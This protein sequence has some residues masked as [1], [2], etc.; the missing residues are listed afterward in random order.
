MRILL[1]SNRSAGHFNPLVPFARACVRAGHQVLVSAP[2]PCREHVDRAGLTLAPHG[3]AR[4]EAIAAIGARARAVDRDE[5]NRIM[6]VDMFAGEHARAALP[7]MLATARS[8]KP[9]VILRET[10]E[11]AS[12][13]VAEELGIPTWHVAIFFAAGGQRDWGDLDG[14]LRRLGARHAGFV[15]PYLTVAPRS[16]EAAPAPPGTLRFRVPA[17]LPER[18][19][20]GTPLVY[21]TF[22]SI[23]PGAGFFPDLFRR[24]LDAL[25]GLDARVL[26]TIGNDADPAELGP[27]PAN[28][29]VERWV[30]QETLHPDAVICHGGSG[31]TLGALRLGV[32]LV[33]VPMFGDQI[34]NA[35]R[36]DEIGAGIALDTSLDG[37]REA[38]E[39]LLGQPRHRRVAE[40]IA[41]EMAALPHIDES[42]AAIT[43]AASAR[44]AP[45]GA[46]YSSPPPPP[47]PSAA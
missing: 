38:V 19:E 4:P 25:D 26:V 10:C 45:A 2:E 9:D 30:P 20:G 13:A 12:L 37:L 21:L 32:P 40:A 29:R 15:S 24:A 28:V 46:A 8:W 44:S 33:C 3:L 11:F 6:L 41:L 47:R 22:G 16:L 34:Q 7:G 35:K 39:T 18:R 43:A 23:A 5:A 14:A 27:V 36:I 31:T 1:A 17:P 42:V